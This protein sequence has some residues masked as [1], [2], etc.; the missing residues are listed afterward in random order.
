MTGFNIFSSPELCAWTC[1]YLATGK[2][3]DSLRGRYIDVE[4]DVEDMANQGEIVQK[5][6]LYDL[7][8]TMLG[9]TPV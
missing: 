4:Y 1:V 5:E 8:V 2:A 9:D 7:T 3:A 6:G